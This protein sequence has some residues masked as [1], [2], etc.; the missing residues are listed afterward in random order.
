[1]M[2]L[3]NIEE[4]SIVTITNTRLPLGNFTKLQPHTSDFHN[5]YNPKAV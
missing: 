3:L 4:G 1:M 5:V 2:N